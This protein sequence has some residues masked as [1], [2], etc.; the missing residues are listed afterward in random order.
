MRKLASVRQANDS[1][2]LGEYEEVARRLEQPSSVNG[3]VHLVARHRGQERQRCLQPFSACAW[4]AIAMGPKRN[5]SV[6]EVR[7][8]E[9]AAS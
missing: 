3:P 2:R 7:L 8:L 1:P 5:R 9:A 4:R 6:S